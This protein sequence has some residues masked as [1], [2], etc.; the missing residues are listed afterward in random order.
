[1][2]FCEKSQEIGQH[3]IL[4]QTVMYVTDLIKV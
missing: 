3:K 2:K 4:D 1:M